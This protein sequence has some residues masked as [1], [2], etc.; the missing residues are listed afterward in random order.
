[1]WGG[2][3]NAKFL[4]C[5]F[6]II[7]DT[8]RNLCCTVCDC[9]CDIG[10]YNI[11]F[12]VTTCSKIY[13]VSSNLIT[14]LVTKNI[15]K[16]FASFAKNRPKENSPTSVKEAKCTRYRENQL[17]ETHYTRNYRT[18]GHNIQ[19]ISTE[20]PLSLSVFFIAFCIVT[21]VTTFVLWFVMRFIS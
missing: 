21:C 2:V 14:W 9:I 19:Y 13:Y 10:R 17:P 15:N 1:M 18:L 8:C 6:D 4:C 11:K 3:K 7:C 5:V 12:C 20:F 16:I